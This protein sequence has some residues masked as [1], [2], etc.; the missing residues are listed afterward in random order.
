M[1][2][3]GQAIKPSLD[4]TQFRNLGSVCF[5]FKL[6]PEMIFQKIGCLVVTSNLVK[7]KSISSWPKIRAKTTEND[8]RFH[9]HFKWF[10]ALENR[11]ERER[12]SKKIADVGARRSHRSKTISPLRSFKPTLIEPSHRSSRSSRHFRTTHEERDRESRE[13]VAPSARLS[14]HY[15]RTR[16]HQI[17]DEPTCTAPIAPASHTANPRTRDHSTTNRADRTSESH[18]EP[19]TDSF[20]FSFE[21]FVIKFVCDFDFFLSLFDLWFC[22]CCCGGVGGG[23]LVVFLL[24]GGGFCGGGG[25]K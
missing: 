22:C 1:L 19:V 14:R 6:I 25:G 24:C 13:I 8:F 21:I 4:E 5:D 17:A 11:R 3:F 7:L 18:H 20:S 12:K 16:S 9:F 10:P 23:V 2:F 15:S